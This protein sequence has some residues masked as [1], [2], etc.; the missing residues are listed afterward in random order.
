MSKY[1]FLFSVLFV[2]VF[3]IFIMPCNRLNAKADSQL[4]GSGTIKDTNISWTLD[5]DG[6]LTF[7]GVGVLPSSYIWREDFVLNMYPIVNVVVEDGITAIENSAFSS[8]LEVETIKLPESVTSIGSTAFNLCG[9]LKSVNIP[10]LVTRIEDGVFGSCYNLKSIYFYENIEYIGLYA[11][12]NTGFDYIY[13]PCGFDFKID[14]YILRYNTTYGV[15]AYLSDS[16]VQVI[17]HNHVFNDWQVSKMATTSELG[18]M[19]RV[20]K[21]GTV[22]ETSVLPKLDKGLSAWAIIG[23]VL[24]SVTLCGLAV[25]G[26]LLVLRKRQTVR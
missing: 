8:L 25:T 3:C 26:I 22:H 18:E 21:C 20:C 7:S 11:F 24:G 14:E 15:Q 9:R 17:Y 4:L 13:V 6:L 2:F 10:K 19:K 23:I 5:S 1:K 12:E 16:D